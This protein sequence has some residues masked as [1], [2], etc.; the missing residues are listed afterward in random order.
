MAERGP[1]S[2]KRGGAE[3]RGEE[4]AINRRETCLFEEICTSPIATVQSSNV[5]ASL[6]ND[7]LSH[8]FINKLISITN[9]RLH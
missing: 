2:L 9:I 4:S 5:A 8:I 3:E 1:E 7:G 6:L